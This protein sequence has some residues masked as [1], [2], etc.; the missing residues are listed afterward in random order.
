[1]LSNLKSRKIRNWCFF[2]FGISSYPTL[3]LTFFYGA[4][5]A[6]SIASSPEIGTSNWGFSISLAS[7]LSFLIFSV[8]LIHGKIF[9]KKI[10]M[11]FFL[12]F[13]YILVV[14]SFSLFFFGKGSNQFLPL[15]IIVVSLISFEVVNLFYNLSLHKVSNK[16]EEGLISNLGWGFGYLGGLISLL[17]VFSFIQLTK[18]YEYQILGISVFLLVGPFVGI[19][20]LIFGYM[21]LRDFIKTVFDIPTLIDFFKNVKDENLLNFVYSYFFFNNAVV[22]IFAFAGMFASFLFGLTESDILFLGVF[23]N[24]FGIVGCFSL[25]RIEDKIGSRRII[26][27]CI[28]SLFICTI[29]LYFVRNVLIFWIIALIIGFFIGPIQASSRS[30]IAK[31]IKSKNQISAFCAFSMFGNMCAILGPFFVGFV[32]R[33]TN[34]VQYGLLIIPLF[35]GLSIFPSLIRGKFNV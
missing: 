25:G 31:H 12:T 11:S 2:D 21:H 13:F 6:R 33:L 29:S 17:I 9:F 32:I 22:S 5:Y 10:K 24:L 35:L 27:I 15:L 23:I 19:W 26:S 1:M 18:H 16:N 14:S 7:I 30:V 8:I 4:F 3:I 20:T 28:I 34:D